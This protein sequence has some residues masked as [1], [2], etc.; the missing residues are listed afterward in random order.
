MIDLLIK[1][2]Y[3]NDL[4]DIGTGSGNLAITVLH[5]NLAK[6]IV[7]TDV[8]ELQINVAKYNKTKICPHSNINF[9]K[10]QNINHTNRSI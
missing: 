10:G 4:L 8:S 6:N 3:S 9:V 2:S 1:H 7:A 5:Q